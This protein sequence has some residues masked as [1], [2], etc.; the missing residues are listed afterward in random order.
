MTRNRAAGVMSVIGFAFVVATAVT[1]DGAAIT[2]SLVNPG[3][4]TVSP[5]VPFDLEIRATFDAPL[6][7]TDYRLRA[8]GDATATMIARSQNPTGPVGLTYV[9]ATSQDPFESGLPYN[10]SASTLKEVAY[11]ADFG[12]EPGGP[13]DGVPASAPNDVVLDTITIVATGTGSLTITLSSAKAAT[14]TADA[15]DG[16]MFDSVSIDNASI[17]LTV[18]YGPGDMDGDGDVDLDD[19]AAWESCLGGPEVTPGPD[20][21]AADLDSDNDVDLDDFAQFQEAFTG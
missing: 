18:A 12:G 8:S 20:C 11:D 10:L 16:V 4:D 17:V 21:E 9:S 19:F 1:S 15:P 5:A 7:A 3:S 13:S 14:T 6:V 2:Y